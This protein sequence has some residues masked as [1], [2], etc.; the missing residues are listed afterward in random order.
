VGYFAGRSPQKL[1]HST[2]FIEKLPHFD[3]RRPP[4]PKPS[5]QASNSVVN[6]LNNFSMEK[7]LRMSGVNGLYVQAFSFC[8]LEV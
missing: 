6:A 2:Q 3:L 4:G 7:G 1:T 8:K 5:R